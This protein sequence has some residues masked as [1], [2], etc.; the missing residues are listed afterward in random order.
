MTSRVVS[1]T[2]TFPRGISS[3]AND[4]Q[5]SQKALDKPVISV[6]PVFPKS[7]RKKDKGLTRVLGF[8]LGYQIKKPVRQLFEGGGMIQDAKN[9]T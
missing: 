8:F 2:C 1:M 7:D 6:G 4:V 5:A 9:P 3:D